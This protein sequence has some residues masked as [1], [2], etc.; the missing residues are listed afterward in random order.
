MADDLHIFEHTGAEN[1]LDRILVEHLS[2]T[3]APSRSQIERWIEQ[4]AVLISGKV[5]TKPAFKV[6]PGS[7]I[8]LRMPK[9]E[10][11]HLTPFNFPLDVLFEDAHLIVLNKP[12][13]ISMHPGAGNPD[14]SIANAV[15]AH[16]GKG[17]GAVGE[18][19][20]PGI[21]HRIDKDTTGVVVIAKST[22]VH[23][24][25]S[26]QFAERSVRRGYYA[27]VYSTPRAVRTIQ[28]S[29]DGEVSAP[30]GRH[31][32]NRKIMA[33][34]ERGRAATTTWRVI[35]RFP[36]G[37][38]LECRLKTGRT[39]QIRVHMNNIGSPVIGDRSYGDFSNLPKPLRDAATVL[40]RQALHAASL[41]FT[42]PVTG[43]RLSFSAPLPRDF[44]VL[45]ALF[46]DW[47]GTGL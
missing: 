5:V 42:H 15:I 37:T 18:P 17:Q 30:I 7:R 40:G 31:P 36:H 23:A 24:A 29:D 22:P 46:R 14:N 13:G 6:S 32:T 25:L 10:S 39:H 19:D 45:V 1:R 8:E 41:A 4:G 3:A 11:S 21:V 43:A 9:A 2:H 34:S 47:R 16:V 28:A 38:L 27:L 26:K 44:E 20:R 33:I 12:A 35:E